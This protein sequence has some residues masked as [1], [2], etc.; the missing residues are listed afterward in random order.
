[1]KTDCGGLIS[2]ADIDVLRWQADLF[3]AASY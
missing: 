2:L 1:L 3:P